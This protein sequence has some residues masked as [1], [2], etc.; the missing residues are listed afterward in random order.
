MRNFRTYCLAVNF[1]KQTRCHKLPKNLRDQLERAAASI[2]LNLAEGYGRESRADQKRFY[3][4]AMGSLR[5]CQAI[6]ELAEIEGSQA[7]KTL[8]SLA[9]HLVKLIRCYG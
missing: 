9:A 2:A 3:S 5:E 8:D 4:I 1:Y 7:W 6:L